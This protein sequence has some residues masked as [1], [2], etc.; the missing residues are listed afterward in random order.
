[1]S[2]D[3]AMLAVAVTCQSG[4]P[5][6]C[7]RSQPRPADRRQRRHQCARP[8]SSTRSPRPMP[9]ASKLA[10]D[11]VGADRQRQR[12][13]GA[14]EV[15][16]VRGPRPER[17]RWTAR[18]IPSGIPA[19][20]I[21]AGRKLFDA[22]SAATATRAGCGARATR[23]SCHRQPVAQ[24]ACEVDLGVAAPPGSFCTT[25]T[26]DRRSGRV[27]SISNA[28]LEEC[29]FVQPRRGGRGQR[30]RQQCRR[31]RKGRRRPGGG[32]CRNPRRMRWAATTMATD[33][34]SATMCSRCSACT[35]C[36]PTCTT[37]PAKRSPAWWATCKHRTG[38]GRFS[39]ILDTPGGARQGRAVPGND[40]RG[41]S[42]LCRNALT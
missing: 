27:R 16:A 24:I 12:A 11:P 30:H 20:Q 36:S 7:A 41:Y 32:C 3:R 21:N 25:A 39:D 35:W 42:H 2:P 17:R 18:E 34:A 33:A 5:D 22:S 1:M 29:R 26:G 15:G 23:T 19:A 40:R 13:D 6:Q 37:A 4:L 14:E 28:F 8:A 38:N 9:G 10:V 31:G